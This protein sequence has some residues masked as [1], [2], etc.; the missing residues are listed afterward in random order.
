MRAVDLHAPWAGPTEQALRTRLYRSRDICGARAA[1]TE[2]WTHCIFKTAEEIAADCIW[3]RVDPDELRATAD[4]IGFMI[5]AG[6]RRIE[7]GLG[8]A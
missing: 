3:R 5:L 1:C 2:G 6:T 7:A 4:A 8:N